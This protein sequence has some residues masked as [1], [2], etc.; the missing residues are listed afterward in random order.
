MNW[1]RLTKCN[2]KERE[3]GRQDD[4]ETE[5]QTKKQTE[6]QTERQTEL[7]TDRKTGRVTERQGGRQ[8]ETE[9]RGGGGHVRCIW[10]NRTNL[11]TLKEGTGKEETKKD[12]KKR[13]WLRDREGDRK[14][15]AG[16]DR[17]KTRETKKDTKK[18]SLLKT[19]GRPSWSTIVAFITTDHTKKMFC[20]EYFKLFI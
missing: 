20:F 4:R 8:K 1:I 19:N 14:V 7:Q 13:Q 15:I 6:K 18:A 16:R 17:Q 5:K 10:T 9:I 11:K 12:M 3:T 2:I